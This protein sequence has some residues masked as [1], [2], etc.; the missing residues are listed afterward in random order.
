MGDVITIATEL[1][2]KGFEKGSKKLQSAIKSLGNSAKSLLSSFKRIIPTIIGVGS[3]YQV[4]S[5]AVNAFMSQNQ[6]LSAKMNSVWTALGNVLG[7][8][9]TQ[10][11][12]WV[13]TAVSYFLEFLR[14]LGV[15]G[16][17]ANQLSKKANQAGSELKKTI[18][19]FDELNLLNDSG[20]GG[21]PNGQLEDKEAPEWIQDIADFLKKGEWE[22]AGQVLAQKLNDMVNS[23]DWAGIGSRIGY[24]MNGAIEFIASTIRNFDWHN[25]GKKL[26]EFI[27]NL[28]DEIKWTDVGEL[29]VAGF[30]TIFQMV[31]GFL[32]EFDPATFAEAI[33]GIISGAM[34]ALSRAIINADYKRIGTNIRTMFALIDWGRIKEAFKELLVAAVQGAIDLLWGL[35]DFEGEPPSVVSVIDGIIQKLF[36]LALVVKTIVKGAMKVLKAALGI[37]ETNEELTP[38]E[39]AMAN[40]ITLVKEITEVVGGFLE[41]VWN[42]FLDALGIGKPSGEELTPVEQTVSN[43]ITL[44]ATVA[45]KITEV[46]LEVWNGFKDAL[47]IGKPSGEELTPV[48][49]TVSNIITLI[50]TIVEKINEVFLGVWNG[51]KDALGIGKPSGE[52]LTPV[53]QTVSDIITLITTVVEKINEVFLEVWNGFKDALGIGEP[54]DRE[55]TPVEK[56]ISSIVS[57]ISEISEL[58]TGFIGDAWA[59][60]T[61]VFD[62]GSG[63]TDGTPLEKILS[64]IQNLVSS[65]SELVGS[66]SGP[67]K[68]LWDDVLAPMVG[69]IAD[70]AIPGAI[71][72]LSGALSA[73][74]GVFNDSGS[75]WVSSVGGIWGVLSEMLGATISTAKDVIPTFITQIGEG[76]NGLPT[77]LYG[78]ASNL[79][80]IWNTFVLPAIQT[81]A[82]SGVVRA[83]LSAFSGFIGVCDAVLDSV[84]PLLIQFN[85]DFLQ[86]FI[87]LM[88]KVSTGLLEGLTEVFR[89]IAGLVRGEISFGEMMDNLWN[90]GDVVHNGF[91]DLQQQLG[92]EYRTLLP[93]FSDVGYGLWK[94]FEGA[95]ESDFTSYDFTG[96]EATMAELVNSMVSGAS[97]IAEAEPIV[98]NYKN[99]IDELTAA[100]EEQM[101][102]CTDSL[103]AGKLQLQLEGELASVTAEY[104]AQL[105][106]LGYTLDEQGN[107][108]KGIAGAVQG[109]ADAMKEGAD[110]TAY[111]AEKVDE[112]VDTQGDVKP[113]SGAAGD[114]YKNFAEGVA[115]SSGEAEG[116]TGDMGDAVVQTY[117]DIQAAA[118]ETNTEV[119]TQ[120]TELGEGITSSMEANMSTMRSDFAEGT[121]DLG[122]ITAEQT[123]DAINVFDTNMSILSN[124]AFVWGVDMMGNLAL[125]IASGFAMYVGP[126]MMAVATGIASYIHYSEPDKGPLAKT[127]E[128]MPD[129]MQMLAKGIE[130]NIPTVAKSASEV[131]GAISDELHDEYNVGDIGAMTALSDIAD[132]VKLRV[133]AIAEGSVLPYSVNSASGIGTASGGESELAGLISEFN[134]KMDEIIYLLDNVQFVAQFGDMRALARQIKKELRREQISEGR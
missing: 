89:Q 104:V 132:T 106:E 125:G 96:F 57:L 133:P 6:E 27:N 90:Y 48:E 116:D 69:F 62:Y 91:A 93:T 22:R 67:L 127:H 5:K 63:T 108:V 99:K 70:T 121:T 134:G 86:P 24:Y 42:G 16:K 25:L 128:F 73:L 49:Q 56:T 60:L 88:G 74:A 68:Q 130:D 31:T 79:G 75:E 119:Q 85:N 1:S 59:S 35:L 7:P 13:T 105:A 15:T 17:T 8:I 102:T 64:S 50:T 28:F 101:Q 95:L 94:A 38:A 54:V 100:Y 26:A 76:L 20:G 44:V 23:V 97:G 37:G 71:D 82:D 30:T 78:I 80:K 46:F 61:S 120:F 33:T 124:H 36:Q 19:G 122:R 92:D 111:A 129:M 12:N 65:V 58:I 77:S 18:A 107:I 117:E 9:I 2:T 98:T 109:E 21:G 113:A 87:E 29:A 112:L 118:E 103:T 115:K 4:I 110:S 45:E 131:A 32:E 39:R 55:L 34:E 52:G 114:A 81:T 84:M 11:I 40:I 14:L 53:E 66:V 41:Q 47:G 83:F 123:L 72:L 51:F 43:I 126:V 10:I 3:A